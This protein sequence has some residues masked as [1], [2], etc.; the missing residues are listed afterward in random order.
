MK[1]K[2][3]KGQLKSK[4][5]GRIKGKLLKQKG[6]N[7]GYETTSIPYVIQKN[8][9][10]DF[11]CIKK[12]N[13]EIVYVEVKGYFRVEDRIKMIAVKKTNPTLDIRF[14]FDKNNKLSSK[15]K[16]TYSEWCCKYGFPCAIGDVPKDWF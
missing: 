5:E 11:T 8:Y 7:V 3:K 12:E 15:S 6:I 10:P 4:L 16:M 1:K 14:V 9:I 2:F 13:G